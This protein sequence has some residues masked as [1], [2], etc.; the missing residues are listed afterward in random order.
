MH[1]SIAENYVSNWLNSK[2]Y[3]SCAPIY[4]N[5]EEHIS[6][7]IQQLII[8]SKNMFLTIIHSVST[9]FFLYYFVWVI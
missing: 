4:D 6:Y 9:C 2:S 1:K 3:L 7:D 5:P 8:L